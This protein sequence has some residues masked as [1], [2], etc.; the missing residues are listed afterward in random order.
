LGSAVTDAVI[1]AVRAWQARPLAS[2]HALVC[3]DALRVQIR[4]AGLV[5]NKAVYLALG[6]RCSGHREVRGRWSAQT[7]G[8]TCRRRVM[9]ERKAR[10]RGALLSAGVDGRK[11]VAAA[12]TAGFPDPLGQTGI[13]HLIRS[14]TPLASWQERKPL[15]Q[16]R[17]P[18]YP[19]DG[20]ATAA[21]ALRAFETGPWGE[22]VPTVA[23][24]GRHHW[25][26]LLPCFAFA[27]P[28]RQIL[29][30]TNAI[31]RLPGGVRKR[32]RNQGHFPKEA[33]ATT[34]IWL[35]LRNPPAK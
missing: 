25:P 20:A 17:Q 3:V 27:A 35:A 6:V 19:A 7:E 33:A 13:V 14:A 10:G 12:I 8:A 1:A 30:P 9:N 26:P 16:V 31:E 11:G 15:A 21:Q 24:R 18:S 23:Q 2:R 34:L 32:I 5:R 4:D 28:V 22:R 29:Y